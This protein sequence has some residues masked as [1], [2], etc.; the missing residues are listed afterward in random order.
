MLRRINNFIPYISFLLIIVSYQSYWLV[1]L[2]VN[3]ID[4]KLF[5][6]GIFLLILTAVCR[7]GNDLWLCGM[8]SNL[9]GSF[10]DMVKQVTNSNL[11]IGV[12]TYL[13]LF[14]IILTPVFFYL[15]P[16][17]NTHGRE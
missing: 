16:K 17:T 12:N 10:Y 3:D 8:L 13:M 4:F 14:L 5:A 6:I 11:I 15:K 9:F 2:K 1:Q 7:K